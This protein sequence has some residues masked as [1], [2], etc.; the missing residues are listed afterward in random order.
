MAKFCK[1]CGSEL[2]GAGKFCGSCGTPVPVEI[3]NC[4][5]CGQEWDGKKKEV[6]AAPAAATP[7]TRKAAEPE[8]VIQFA[9][10][11]QSRRISRAAVQPVYG[12]QY[13]EG[14]DCPNCGAANMANKT[15]KTCESE[16]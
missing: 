4:P 9:E 5:T 13:V 8:V 10:K 15:C 2:S 11:K 1:E 3:H 12:S 16:N 6:K 14:K 7:R